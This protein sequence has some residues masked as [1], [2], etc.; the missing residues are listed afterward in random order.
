MGKRTKKLEEPEQKNGK[1]VARTYR[2]S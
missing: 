2:P 1:V